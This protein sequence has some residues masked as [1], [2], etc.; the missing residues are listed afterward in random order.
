MLLVRPVSNCREEQNES[1]MVRTRFRF[2]A[3]CSGV[4]ALEY[5]MWHA[6][7]GRSGPGEGAQGKGAT[8]LEDRKAELN[9]ENRASRSTY[10]H[11]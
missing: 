4:C 2:W 9:T 1:G 3:P 8:G 7:N 11:E 5:G 6:P 10:S